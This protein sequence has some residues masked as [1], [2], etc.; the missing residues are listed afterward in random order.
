MNLGSLVVGEGGA[1]C[2]LPPDQGR[3]P[4]LLVPLCTRHP[5]SIVFTPGR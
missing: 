1:G 2:F 5:S 3:V 4:T